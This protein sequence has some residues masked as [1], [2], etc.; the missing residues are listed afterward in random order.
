VIFSSFTFLGLFLPLVIIMYF[1]VKAITKNIYWQNLVLCI[2]SLIFYSWGEPIY[3]LLMLFSILINYYFAILI[4]KSNKENT[5][6]FFLFFSVI[7]NLFI[8]GFFKYG[9]FL[10]NNL[11]SLFRFSLPSMNLSLPIGISFFTFQIMSYVIDVYRKDVKAQKNIMYLATYIA[12][13][14]QLIAG[15]IV[16][17]ETIE[18][19]LETRKITLEAIMEG[20]KR[21]IIGLAKKVII[22]NNVAFVCDSIYSSTELSNNGIFLW[23]A[24][25]A[26]TIQI[27]FDFS[28]YSDMAIGLG[29]IF[30]FNFLEN[31]NYPYISKSVTDFWK[32]WH[33]SLSSWFKDYVYI[34]L[35]GNRVS[36]LKIIRNVLFVWLLTG[37]WHGASWNFVIWGG[38]YG[39]ILLIEKFLLIK[40]L[41]KIP[42]FFQHLYSISIFM[43]G[44]L[45]FRIENLN[46]IKKIVVKMFDLN[47]KDF[48]ILLV[49]NSY[50]I[51]G[52]IFIIIGIILSTPIIRNIN[53]QLSKYAWW[54]YVSSIFLFNLLFLSMGMLLS[55]AYNPFIYFRF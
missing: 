37:L 17:Y 53:E 32:R 12:F 27:Y 51:I 44:W 46:E 49:E 47:M 21:F 45:I 29:K 13:F 1:S 9:N 52:I 36:K 22:A 43:F 7:I 38:Y 35:G 28:G 26:Y 18:E 15:P 48:I 4:E 20:I 41:K 34:P 2:F 10:I 14:P 6:K 11:N 39:I 16:R 3:I 24:L 33:I 19:E 40:L 42:N 50:L 30:G 31:F 5:K 23:I 8:I 55:S 54:Y 25:F